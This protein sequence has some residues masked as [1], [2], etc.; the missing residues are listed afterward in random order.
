[1][2]MIFSFKLRIIYGKRALSTIII[3][4]MST[5]IMKVTWTTGVHG[6]HLFMRVLIMQIWLNLGISISINLVIMFQMWRI[7]DL[8]CGYASFLGLLIQV[9]SM[10]L[11]DL[12]QVWLLV[13]HICMV[14][15]RHMAQYLIINL[16]RLFHI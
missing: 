9:M 7:I 5:K 12:L 15:T 1:M 2:M 14:V 16:S 11:S 10:S 6:C 4:E 13:L 8:C 3:E